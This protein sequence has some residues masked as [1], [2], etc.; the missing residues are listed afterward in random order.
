MT[1]QKAAK[2]VAAIGSRV[3]SFAASNGA[4]CILVV[5]LLFA[6]VRYKG[7]YN[8][9]NV[10]AILSSTDLICIGLMA[11]GLTFVISAG[12]IDL[13]VA[14]IAVGS[15]IVAALLAPHGAVVA[16]G[17]AILFGLVLGLI[18]GVL[19]AYVGLPSFIV[20]LAMLLAMRGLALIMANRGRV[21]VD[22]SVDLV[23]FYNL[24]IAGIIPARSRCPRR[25]PG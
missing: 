20:T 17:G 4:L 13:S 25:C 16:V 2:P 18:N 23:T 6:L 12:E 3:R 15:S 21:P 10:S 19:V 22:Y 9:F 11:I 24:K 5:V 8:P 14:G 1:Y 7:F